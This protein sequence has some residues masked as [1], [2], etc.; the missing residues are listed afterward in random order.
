VT[1]FAEEDNIREVVASPKSARDLMTD[2]PPVVEERKK[3]RRR[4]RRRRRTR[5][6]C[7]SS[8]SKRSH[9][10]RAEG[11]E[12]ERAPKIALRFSA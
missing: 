3:K 10:W 6:N 2:A 1:I 8:T 11:P 4:R 7:G 9:R 12:L 5:S